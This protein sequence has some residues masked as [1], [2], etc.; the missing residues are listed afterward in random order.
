[1]PLRVRLI[2]VLGRA[3]C[4]W[5]LA[6]AGECRREHN[7]PKADRELRDAQGQI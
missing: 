5:L 1:M 4:A 7:E 2:G 6:K 3:Q